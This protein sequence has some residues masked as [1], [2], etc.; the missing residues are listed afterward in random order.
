MLYEMFVAANQ[1]RGI[2]EATPIAGK[3]V[4]KTAG[5]VILYGSIASPFATYHADLVKSIKEEIPLTAICASQDCVRRQSTISSPS[6]SG[7]ICWRGS[8]FSG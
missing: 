5:P 8:E 4:R 2:E 6:V 1:I 3:W 7:Y